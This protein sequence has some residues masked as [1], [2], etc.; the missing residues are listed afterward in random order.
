MAYYI[1]YFGAFDTVIDIQRYSE[2]DIEE[3]HAAVRKALKD[4]KQIQYG[5]F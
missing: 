3:Y 2:K 1:V 4:K 5:Y